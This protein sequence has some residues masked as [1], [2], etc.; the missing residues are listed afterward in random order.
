MSSTNEFKRYVRLPIT[1]IPNTQ[2]LSSK[3]FRVPPLDGSLTLPEIWDWHLEYSPNHPLFVYN[4]K[5]GSQTTLYFREA[6][7]AIHRAGW[8]VRSRL[9]EAILDTRPVIA[10]L[11]MSG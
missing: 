4:E 6:I 11:A 7:H 2:G 9:P 1:G 8:L 10:I 5:D 3:T